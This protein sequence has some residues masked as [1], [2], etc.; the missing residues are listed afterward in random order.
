[1]G[2]FQQ[3]RPRATLVFETANADNYTGCQQLRGGSPWAFQQCLDQ[4]SSA[5]FSLQGRQACQLGPGF[6][7]ELGLNTESWFDRGAQSEAPSRALLF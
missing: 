2:A 7:T 4:I 3:W 1:M 5:L 6:E